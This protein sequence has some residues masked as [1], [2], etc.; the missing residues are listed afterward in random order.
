MFTRKKGYERK[1]KTG[2]VT[3][4]LTPLERMIVNAIEKLDEV[5]KDEIEECLLVYVKV[6]TGLVAQRKLSMPELPILCTMFGS[7]GTEAFDFAEKFLALPDCKSSLVSCTAGKYALRFLSFGLVVE[8]FKVT[9]KL[10]GEIGDNC[11]RLFWTTYGEIETKEC[12]RSLVHDIKEFGQNKGVYTWSQT[13]REGNQP[14]D[15]VATYGLQLQEQL[16]VRG[17]RLLSIVQDRA[18]DVVV[19]E[20]VGR[21]PRRVRRGAEELKRTVSTTCD[22]TR[23]MVGFDE[24]VLEVGRG[25]GVVVRTR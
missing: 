5:K 15:L 3:R 13:L 25:G 24:V 16:R 11:L 10:V 4:L 6:N 9:L 18:P 7:S 8:E 12:S 22:A 21:C 19:L 20:G 1:N 14:A 23:R 17:S 2:K